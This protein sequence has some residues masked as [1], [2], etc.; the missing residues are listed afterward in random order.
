MLILYGSQTGTAESY[1]KIVH[2][3][4][5][6]RGLASRM[7]PASSYDMAALP[8]E[9]ENVV[10]F[11]TSTFYNGEFPNNFASCWEYLKNDAPAMLNL[12]FGVFGLGCSTTKDNFN[13]AAKSVRARLLDLEAVEL[14]PAAYGDEHDACGHETA[15]RPWIK[16]LWTALLGDDQKMTLPV[17]Y[18]VRQFHMD[19]PRDFGPSFGNFTVV[20]NELLTPEGYE[21][22]TYLLTMD[23]PD[24]MS[25]QTG[26]HVQL[27]Y[28]NPD[29]LVERAAARLRLNLDTVVQMQPLE[30]NLPKTFPS[31]A[32]VTVRALLKEYLDLASPPSRSFLEGLSMLASDPEEAAYLQNLAEDMGVGNL[33][34][35]YVSGGMLREPFTL[36]DVL[37]DHP[38]I[39]VKLD[40]LLGNVRPIMPRYY[41]ICSSHLVSP[42][43]IQVCYMV[44]QWYC[45]K[46]PTVVIQGA[47]AGFLSHQVPGNRV[48][49]K[50]SRGYFK[51][52]ETLYVPIIG[53][54]LGT[55]IAFFRA[56]MQ[57]RAAMHVE[58]PD[59]PV[60]PLRLYY[61]V[62]HAS[63]DFLFKD[64]L[65]GW[66]EEGLL[67][68]IPACSHD[69]AAFV[70][71]ATKLA[72]HPEKVCEYLDN[73]GV[74]FY[75]GIG[76]VIPNYHEASVL[77]ALME[78]HG[79]ETT[80]AIEASTIEA[81][82]ESGRWQVE[83]FS[84]SLDHENALQQAQDV[85]LNKDRRP[86]ADVLRDCE[87]FCYQCAQT[88]QGVACTKVGVCG[89]TPTV[90]ALQDL[91]M[92]HLKH[93]S[94][95]AHQIRS[96]DA[97]DDSELLR[98]LD[99]FTLDAASS[100][101]TNANFDP[102][103][104][105]A[106]VDKALTF[107]EPLQS[108]YNESAMALDED[109][110]P[111]PWIH[112]EL[113]QSAAA[114]SDVDMED[115]VKHSKKVGVLSRLALRATTRSWACKRCSC[116][117]DAEVQS[118]VHEAFA[119]LLTKDASNVDACI[120][121]LM[122]V[123][124]VNLVAMELLAKANGPQSPATVSIAP[125]SGHAILVS[126]QDLYVVRA[127]V[128]QCAAYEEANGVHINVF[129]H[130]ELLTAHAHE[131]LRASGHL[132]G[133]FGTAWQRQS[134]EFG[135][136][137][138]A[139]LMTT[140]CLTPPQTTYK[141]R[142]FCAGMVGYPDV[143]HL[144]ADDLS[145]LLDK[146]VACAGFTDDDATFSYPPNPFVPSATSYTVGYGVDTLV[147][148]VDEI[149]DAMN[150]GE[151]SRFYIVGGTDGYE[152]ERTYYT[153]L[154][155]ALPPTSV[156]LTFGCG[157]YRMN[158]MDLGT[159]GETGIPR[160]IDLGQCN[161]VL[162][163][164]ELAKAIAAKMDVTVSDLP[165]SIVL[166]W[167]EQKS[168]VTMLTLLSLGICHMRG[169]P[170]T[171]AFLRPSVFEIMRDRYN[172]KMI[173]VSAPRD[174]TNMLYGA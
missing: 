44:D 170:T 149:V 141:D 7:M 20:S 96:L 2:S 70:T 118:F 167:F 135:H 36:I 46:D 50:T 99:A 78:G 102:M 28:T 128:A 27:A 71:P 123:G 24:G 152:G 10:L 15:F 160:L 155:N 25:Y 163:A 159:I 76:G 21:R 54:A 14:I 143:P 19:A 79:D 114:A 148:R 107:Y 131:D 89:K 146:A 139:I 51:I 12:K 92:E 109:P 64:E 58:S 91:V 68:L 82:K 81:L 120:E 133:H 90:A 174:V 32:P 165:L 110:L 142:L 66:E 166:A 16:S 1:A 105:V 136:F 144:A 49:A 158:H 65:H 40:H 172:L 151:I 150:A 83:A 93:L 112:R 26:D 94:W 164:I 157:K 169:G 18:D 38:S 124:Q 55:G 53:V 121:M 97:G 171:P 137:P 130:G 80:A 162:G 104:F 173:S 119:F 72:E 103:H 117:N 95:L 88:S 69:S 156:V 106:L 45:T 43:Q 33:Y 108:L 9:D 140:N 101:L 47:A 161:D 115:L 77:H 75:C 147:A 153:D 145:A 39:K 74:Y 23:L 100:T 73:G 30:S 60:T 42:R 116:A 61:G 5:K 35:R 98:A 29:D 63:K 62:R 67:E 86:I 125:V 11:I 6:A 34:M 168:I 87:M 48:T 31:T 126:G 17:H 22:P 13:R 57:H 111:T 59:A 134:M 84:R 85:V 138:G 127:L 129:T 37:E 41:S 3:F 122:R 154:V 8:L 132:A 113:P 52:P 4:A 56:L